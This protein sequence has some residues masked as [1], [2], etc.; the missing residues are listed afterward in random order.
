MF[1]RVLLNE[2]AMAECLSALVWNVPLVSKH[3]RPT[4]LLRRDEDAAIFLLLL[5][6]LNGVTFSL[7]TPD[8]L[9]D[10]PDYW[11]KLPSLHIPR[12]TVLQNAGEDCVVL[13][14]CGVCVCYICAAS[15]CVCVCVCV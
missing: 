6:N 1:L 10:D 12:R 15:R 9:L 5:E 11:S 3:Y 2:R 8:P 13:C 4:A 14:V 7:A